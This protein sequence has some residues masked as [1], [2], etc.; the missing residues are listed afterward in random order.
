V[1]VRKR[2]APTKSTDAGPFDR[3][4]RQSRTLPSGI[5][6]T[7]L[8][9]SDQRRLSVGGAELGARGWGSEAR[10][11]QECRS[12]LRFLFHPDRESPARSLR[13]ADA[14]PPLGSGERIV[15][16]GRAGI[17][18]RMRSGRHR[19]TS[20]FAQEKASAITYRKQRIENTGDDRV[21]WAS[22]DVPEFLPLL[23]L[24]RRVQ[25]TMLCFLNL[26]QHPRRGEVATQDFLGM[27]CV[28]K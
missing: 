25:I 3:G 8:G 15:D 2:S 13:F 19:Q 12:A 1:R 21:S 20:K 28:A 11:D 14:P 16:A 26:L 22:P 7:E 24:P 18:S 5:C 4:G 23:S 6:L 9:V 17:R 10:E 27:L